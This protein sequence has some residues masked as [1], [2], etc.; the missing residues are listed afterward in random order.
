MKFLFSAFIF[1]SVIIYLE[2]KLKHWRRSSL[3]ECFK[4]DFNVVNIVSVSLIFSSLMLIISLVLERLNI[5]SSGY[6]VFDLSLL[7]YI[8][9]SV[10]FIPI[11]EEYFFRYLPYTVLPSTQYVKFL[12]FG[13]SFLF[14][15][16]HSAVG[17]EYF[18]IFVMGVLLSLMFLKTRN[19]LFSIVSHSMY[20]L[21]VF[22][23]YYFAFD[24]FILLFSIIVVFGFIL[25]CN[26]KFKK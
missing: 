18:Y 16:S 5:F 19:I 21:F 13:S 14:A 10:C 11:V 9:Y 24:S 22:L 4:N 23:N 15:F 8:I 3:L 7:P 25:Y 12:V 26:F 6:G 17:F 1:L 20:N 2:F